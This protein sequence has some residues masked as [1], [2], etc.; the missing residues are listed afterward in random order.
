MPESRLSR[1]IWFARFLIVFVAYY[2][3]GHLG[4]TVPYVGSHISLIWPPTGIALAAL[5]GWELSLWPAILLGALA[6]NLAVGSGPGLAFGIAC[7]NTLGPWLVAR[8]LRHRDFDPN[9]AR[10]RDLVRYLGIAVLGGM[11]INAS[12][13]VI[14]LWLAGILPTPAVGAAWATWW[15]GD[16]MGALVMGIPLLTARRQNWRL[17]LSG[18]RGGEL[19]TLVVL[20]L[21]VG[22]WVFLAQ[23][24]AKPANPLLY[25]PFFLLSWLAIRGGAS[26]AS[27]VALLLAAEAVWATAHGEGPF[28]SSDMHYNLA[29]LWGYMATATVIT[30]LITVL[31][32]ELRSSERRLT[33]ATLGGQVGL[34]EWHIPSGRVTY[35]GDFQAVVGIP[36]ER[37]GPSRDDWLA[38]VHPDDRATREAR[39]ADHLA[40]G[41]E[42]YE[43]EY[44]LQ[45]A[46]QLV[47][48]LARGQVVE[49]DVHGSPLRM[50]G[51]VLNITERKRIE[52]IERRQ[53]E[54]L[55]RL[56]EI[57]AHSHLPPA[58]RWQRALAIVGRHLGLEFAI[59][60][61]VV[62]KTYTIFAHVSPPDTL[63]DGQSF[64]LG[65]TYCD[66]TLRQ[67]GVVAIADIKASP[68][69]DHPCYRTFRLE[70][71]IG[72]PVSVGGEIFGTVNFS[73]AN[74]YL[75]TFD[76]ADIEFVN[77]LAR[78]VGSAIERDQSLA[79][80]AASE[81]YL[82]AIID[83]QP[84]CVK[85]MA[86]NGTLQQMNQVG[87][88]MLEIGSVEEANAGNL[89]DFIV[90]EDRQPFLDL[91][92]R[93]FA[94]HSGTLEFRIVGKR[95]RSLWLDTHAA[96]LRDG[97]GKVTSLLAVTRDI[98]AKKQ[99]E[100]KLR[101]A[102]SVFTHAHE[103]I[104]ICDADQVVID[105]NPTFTEITG[106]SR[107]EMLGSTPRHLRSVGQS[108]E[109]Y[110][111]MWQ[112]INSQGYWEGELWNQR[113]DG[114]ML[115]ERLTISRVVDEAGCVTHYIGSFSDITAL[116]EQQ[117]QLEYLAH[118][119]PLTRLPNR[120]LLSDRMTQALAQS[121]RSGS[122]MALCYLDL[123]GFKAI[124]DQHGHDAGDALL[125]EVARR[126]NHTLR[127][128]DT[129][130][131]LGGDEFVLLLVGI[132]VLEECDRTVSRILKTIAAP[133]RVKGQECSVS[134]SI[135][136]TIYPDD[137]ADPDTLLRH[138]DQAMY[139]A[140]QCGKNRYQLYD[141]AQ[142]LEVRSR[143]E[144][145]ERI[146]QGLDHGEF[147][148]HYQPIVNMQRGKVLSYEGLIRWQHPEKGLLLP[149][150]FLPV[151]EGSE[152]DVAL[153]RWV[154][155]EGIRQ[156]GVWRAMG[157]PQTLSLNVA[158]G[159]LLSPGFV[160]ELAALLAACPSLA[161]L[162]I[163]IDVSETVAVEHLE[164][165][166]EIFKRCQEVGVAVALDDFGAGYSSLSYFR[167][168][169][170]NTLK[171]DQMF[172]QSILGNAEDL[173]IVD[174]VINITRA[175]NRNLSAEGVETSEIGML[176]LNMGCTVGQGYG[177][178][179]PMSAEAVPEWTANFAPD[180]E[181]SFSTTNF[182]RDDL[183]LY[184]AE[185]EHR[186]WVRQL[187]AWLESP[188][189]QSLPPPTA[190]DSCRFG[191][192]LGEAGRTRYGRYAAFAA[193]S[194]AHEAFHRLG[195]DLVQLHGEGRSEAARAQFERLETLRDRLIDH[196]AA[197]QAEVVVDRMSLAESASE[198]PSG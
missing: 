58:E 42:L 93:V 80:L 140:K 147:R 31:V 192:W 17:L 180:P 191:Q 146:R 34:W 24:A 112:S 81:A 167:R 48:V 161:P 32:E 151:I 33:M 22:A 160:D 156:L 196:L 159:H 73:S 148:L 158:T 141:A 53:R 99:A 134:G 193:V 143:R 144:A 36:P 23:G 157:L 129:V 177:I 197:L 9:L 165:V 67:N 103:G 125:I 194:D 21:G 169:P 175:F 127:A 185:L 47:W 71:Y 83:N 70:A 54:C 171:I 97:T 108:D 78:W 176:L 46:P 84:E 15:L 20:T 50:A 172:V 122:L 190:S 154:F 29:M 115:A 130:A 88:D 183:P 52:A 109:F 19:A 51:T 8:W 87:L 10:R 63:Q 123:D 95:G 89:L 142:D 94:G 91:R 189:D 49:R 56:N 168:L 104:M 38:L 92:Q 5:L 124:N 43:A 128:G 145:Q 152:L 77:L 96:P 174:S 65:N 66:I 101:L 105:V 14:Q 16:A 173:A 179:R 116:K 28:Q 102:A 2:V 153:G 39:L 178:A 120:T 150:A 110:Q 86:P 25:L 155:A 26:L 98:T 170:V 12:N 3:G 162:S 35:T 37:L 118:Y 186:S 13:G 57:A 182:S 4:L 82:Q 119:D 131:R 75:R 121:K 111:A 90:P 1:P 59:I 149:D 166:I 187:G 76:D 132:K 113:R 135:G 106:Y 79:R 126:L 139:A 55:V 40:G 27:T 7:G 62:G 45:G 69:L 117:T 68:Y 198:S 44:R 11:A 114:R 41:T 195:Q 64:E 184:M 85:V 30:V 163:G 181:W 188:S 6:V 100:S 72:A 61:Q 164:K 137:D 60:S 74:P 18:K 136:V 138:A 133:I 107:E